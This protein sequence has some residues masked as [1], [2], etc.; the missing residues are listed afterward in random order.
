[1]ADQT[2]S[3]VA[4]LYRRAGFGL[5]PAELDRLAPAGY[6][7]AV[8]TVVAGLGAPDPGGDAIPVPAVHPRPP[9]QPGQPVDEAARRQEAA[10]VKADTRSLQQWWMDRMISTSTPLR[11]KLTLYW[12]GHFATSVSKVRDA[13]LMYLQNQ[14]FRTAG[15]GFQELVDAV[16]RDG[17][18]M[19][20]LDTGSD[21]VA[22]PNENFARELQELFTLGV[23]NYTQDDVTAAA[24]AFTGWSFDRAGYRYRFRAAQHDSGT[25]TYLGQSGNWNGDDIIRI[26]VTSPDSARFVMA[27]LWSHFAYPVTPADPVVADLVTAYGT[28]LDMT[29][30]LRAMFLHPA[31]RSPAARTGLIKQPVEYLVGA[32]RALGLNASVGGGPRGLPELAGALGQEL[33]RPPN[34]GGWG[35]NTYWLSSATAQL[36]LEAALQLAGAADLGAVESAP[37]AQRAAALADLLAVDAWGPT[38]TAALNSAASQPPLVTALALVSPEYLLA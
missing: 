7:A 35:Q 11:E 24:R 17:A 19:I 22:H 32:A 36:R 21:R 4:F 16:A 37:A 15:G 1:M 12:H 31:F 29:A 25:K 14:L 27:R 30:A 13:R 5:R 3:D 2:R 18:M 8:E 34:V 9:G 33:F 6:E 23:G 26:D 28:G 10:A 20:W 38:T